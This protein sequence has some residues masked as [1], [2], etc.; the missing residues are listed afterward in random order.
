VRLERW[1]YTV[2]LR[3]RSLFRRAR[4]EQ[5][6]DD[7]LRFHIDRDIEAR[8]AKGLPNEQARLHALRA[9]GGVER[10]KEEC[11][12]ARRIDYVE[13]F[14]QDFGHGIR[15]LRRNPGFAAAAILTLTLGIGANAA[16]FTVVN[17]VLLRAMP[18][19]DPDRL[20]LVSVTTR[21]G[22]FK[23][24]PALSDSD[25][26][27][28]QR[29]DRLF[30]HLAAFTGTSVAVS[31]VGE[32]VQVPAAEVT[33]GFFSVLGVSA[34]LGRTFAAG[35]GS[36]DA[37]VLG[38]KLWRAD[39]NAEREVLGRTITLNGVRHT[40]IGVMPP[41]FDFPNKAQVWKP[42]DI[43][44]DPHMSWMR[45]VLGRLKT[46]ASQQQAQAELDA[47]VRPRVAAATSDARV[48]RIIPVKELLVS[49]IRRPLAIFAG[50]VAFV[51]LIACANVANLL[52][53][54]ALGRRQ[55][56]AIRAALGAG[57]GRLVRQL[58]TESATLA[59]VAGGMGALLTYWAVPAL[60]ALAPRGSIPRIEM[61]R[62][63]GRVLSFVLGLSLL[64]ALLSGLVPALQA[65]RHGRGPSSLPDGRAFTPR[66]DR[67]RGTLVVCEIALALVLLTG[68]GLM[69]KSFLRLR[70]VDPGFH[71]ERVATLTIDLP[72]SAY[73]TVPQIQAF[74]AGALTG[75]AS[76]PGVTSVAA[77]NWL[78]LG[79]AL[80]MGDVQIEG[81]TPTPGY[82][83]DKPCVS[84]GYFHT[85]GIRLIGGR[86]FSDRDQASTPGVAIVSQSVA[87]QLWAG[88]DP[89][90]K[91]IS[92]EDHPRPN[93]WLTIVGVVD[94]VKQQGLAA[95]SHPAVYLPYLQ[96]TRAFWVNHMTFAV[97]TVSDPL[98][99]ASAVRAIIRDLDGNLPAPAMTTIPELIDAT[100]AEPRFQT[101]LLGI[102]AMLALSLTI[103]GV[104]GVIAH[105]VAQ[106]TREIGI[107]VALGAAA[108]A[109]V[110]M[111]LRHTLVL[112]GAGVAMGL[113]GAAG[114]TR[115]L[116]NFLFEVNAG[117][118]AT[119]LM[120]AGLLMAAASIA[121]WIPARRA[122]RVDPMV[123]L[124]HE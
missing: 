51:L 82:L 71:A 103:V 108:P 73:R 17:G 104:Y 93:D 124:R 34:A 54:R 117:D 50:A 39:F 79:G 27:D 118:P 20:Y 37:A 64:T 3:L 28:F 87:R 113:A 90:G 114:V 14:Q 116:Q 22:P 67:L 49:D 107:R 98:P 112:V 35:D 2:P 95:K 15:A 41:G 31:E 25:Y 57:R 18:F 78:P 33:T 109:V 55:E 115:V 4:V 8:M 106:R 86:D 16:V 111:V 61:I 32:P 91:R 63:D 5:E 53:T 100:T 94:D 122:A 43:R 42:I 60:I 123:A 24:G 96:V 75:L 21:G 80:T 119:F 97:Q 65:T 46:G 44:I 59:L 12:D 66:H 48:D 110:W 89:L 84:P 29:A 58:L 102:F 92:V 62:T 7:E 23:S 56:M 76:V 45:P 1:R 6:L 40:V 74:H 120:V 85:M 9:F 69:L 68:A 36:R 88:V 81:G 99:L 47:W 77:V 13:H 38:D 121:G 70:A 26:L 19:P 52:L 11:R 101:R 30:D 72:D 10:R 83:V 105:S